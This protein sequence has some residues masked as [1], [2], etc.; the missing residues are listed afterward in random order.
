MSM[1]L[2]HLITRDRPAE[3]ERILSAVADMLLSRRAMRMVIATLPPVG[4]DKEKA[5]DYAVAVRRVA[6]ARGV[7]VADLYSGF[8]GMRREASLFEGKGPEVNDDGLRFAG[9]IIARSI[10]SGYRAKGRD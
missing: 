8:M 3:F 10:V 6:G 1:G 4:T 9:Q 7:P 5:R 2:N